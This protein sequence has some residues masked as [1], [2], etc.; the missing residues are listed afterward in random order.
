MKRFI[1]IFTI[2]LILT[3]PALLLAQEDNNKNLDELIKDMG[4]SAT[5]SDQQTSNETKINEDTYM[6]SKEP[7]LRIDLKGEHAF[8]FHAPVV[9]PYSLEGYSKSPKS[10]NE[11]NLTV[12]YKHLKMVF[13]GAF[14]LVLNEGGN[15]D[16]FFDVRPLEN[17]I[18]WSPWKFILSAGFQEVNWGAADGINPTG[19]VNAFDYSRGL[20]NFQTIPVMSIRARVMPINPLEIDIVFLP[21]EQTSYLPFDTSTRLSQYF[22]GFSISEEKLEY[23]LANAVGGA[24]INV[25][26]N[27]IDISLSYLYDVDAFFTPVVDTIF[28]FDP[29]TYNSSLDVNINLKHYRIHRIGYDMKATIQSVALWL[30]ACYSLTEDYKL[31]DISIRN[32]NLHYIIGLDFNYGPQKQFYFNFQYTGKFIPGYYHDLFFDYTNGRPN[33]PN[34]TP[35]LTNPSM[36]GK[37][38]E[39]LNDYSDY[40]E[41]YYYKALTHLAAG[42]FEGLLQGFVLKLEWPV[43]N[44]KVVPSLTAAYYLPF[45]YDKNQRTRYGSLLLNPEL[46]FKPRDSFKIG[47]G[48]TLIYAWEKEKGTDE[49]TIASFDSLGIFHADSNI[50]LKVE[51]LWGVNFEK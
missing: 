11:L 38:S 46:L 24:R 30:E 32:H 18:A 47:I 17:Y 31:D 39:Y 48:A 43:Y 37:L 35:Y 10:L 29:T 3:L 6:P 14:D 51:F 8:S 42:E 44:E 41:D 40:L 28:Y 5:K 4:V 22:S 9:H 34:L 16:E 45:L 2:G 33:A 13:S 15:W 20:D 12:R 7:N 49:V 36:I 27:N 25:Y 1:T 21:Y 26:T 23:K 19:N 50:Y